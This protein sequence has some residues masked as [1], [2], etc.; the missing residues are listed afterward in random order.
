MQSVHSDEHLWVEKGT[1]VEI[2]SWDDGN[3][4]KILSEGLSYHLC[5]HKSKDFKLNPKSKPKL[6]VKPKNC[7]S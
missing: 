7:G 5:A 4:N 6:K 3:N 1:K 2:E